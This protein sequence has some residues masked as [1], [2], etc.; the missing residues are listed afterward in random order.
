MIINLKKS[1]RKVDLSIKEME[2]QQ[3]AIYIKKYGEDGS[4]SGQM[5]KDIFKVFK[6]NKTK[7]EKKDK[8]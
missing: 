6:S 2:V 5:L 7:K 3:E 1:L 8:K 4:S